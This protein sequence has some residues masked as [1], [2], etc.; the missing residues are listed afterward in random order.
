MSWFPVS[1]NAHSHPK[2][3][4]AGLEAVGLWSLSGSWSMDNLTDGFIPEWFVK[5]FP[6]GMAVAKQLVA[7]G[8]W[9]PGKKNGDSGWWFHDWKPECTKAEIEKAREQARL[10]K[11]K[12]REARE[13]E[14][15]DV[16]PSVTRDRTRDSHVPSRRPSRGC[17][18]PTQ[19]N[20]TQPIDPLV[21]LGGRVTEVTAR[22]ANSRPSCAKHP[23]GN[24]ADVP[25]VGCAKVREWSREHAA[26]IAA[27]ELEAKRRRRDIADNC[28]DCRGT[29]LVEVGDDEVRKCEHP[30]AAE[31]AHA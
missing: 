9:K 10:R 19:P 4:K 15:A 7:A 11:R 27:D 30:Y 1:D 23:N 2:M 18:G 31:A 29:N 8:L 16:T 3:R 22:E 24:P 25:C 28:P 13:A 6:R 5:Q 26:E 21:D 17:L 12:S 14:S 20:P